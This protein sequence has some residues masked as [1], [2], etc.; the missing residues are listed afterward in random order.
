VLDGVFARDAAG[1]VAFHAARRLT[2]LDVAEVLAAVEPGRVRIDSLSERPPAV[3]VPE[4]CPRRHPG[5]RGRLD[6][7]APG[8]IIGAFSGA[9]A[10]A[11]RQR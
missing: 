6:G 10:T 4:V 5:V 7:P 1:V 9:T 11:K 2:T 8:V 3:G